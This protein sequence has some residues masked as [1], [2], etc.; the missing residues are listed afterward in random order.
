VQPLS[1]P[2]ALTHSHAQKGEDQKKLA[3]E[4][5]ARVA[6]SLETLR[7]EQDTL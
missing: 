4:I 2:Q 3:A 7:L 6:D 5:M 1:R